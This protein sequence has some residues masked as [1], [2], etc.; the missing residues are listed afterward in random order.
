MVAVVT[1]FQT[2]IRTSRDQ[3]VKLTVDEI[4]RLFYT[5]NTG[6]K[7]DGDALGLD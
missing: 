1:V 5:G 2:R 6:Y 4:S 3:N 7:P